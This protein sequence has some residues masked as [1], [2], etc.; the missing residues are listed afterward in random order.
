[1]SIRRQVFAILMLLLVSM[2][3]ANKI[4]MTY[5]LPQNTTEGFSQNESFVLKTDN[6]CYDEFYFS[7]M[8]DVY[9]STEQTNYIVD[10]IMEAGQLGHQSNLLDV[11]CASGSIVFELANRGFLA[12]GIDNSEIA[13]QKCK[14]KEETRRKSKHAPKFI[15]G[16]ISDTFLIE[17]KSLSHISVLGYKLYLLSD[18]NSFFEQCNNLLKRRGIL[19]LQ[20][21]DSEKFVGFKP[22]KLQELES[23]QNID[24]LEEEIE[25]DGQIFLETDKFTYTG[26]SWLKPPDPMEWIDVFKDKTNGNIRQQIRNVFVESENEI[27]GL[28]KNNGFKLLAK[29]DMKP[30]GG[31]NQY[32]YFLQNGF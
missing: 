8:N 19:I 30:V 27:L 7:M 6:F 25:D 24:L 16:E 26:K 13:I 3:I 1:M 28:L 21:I 5:F 14:Q 9:E 2:W 22:P 29:V 17:K 31:N 18:K 10:A 12:H 4:F 23:L 15:L 20:L 11:Q 32:L